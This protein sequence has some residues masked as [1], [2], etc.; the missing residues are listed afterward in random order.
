MLSFSAML[1]LGVQFPSLIDSSL[2]FAPCASH[3]TPTPPVLLLTLFLQPHLVGYSSRLPDF[4]VPS[5]FFDP[6]D[7]SPMYA[8]VG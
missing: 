2:S 6:P 1:Q 3:C 7:F 5:A 4:F 8:A